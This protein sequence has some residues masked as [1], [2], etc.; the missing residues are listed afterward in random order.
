MDVNVACGNRKTISD[1]TL[2]A[3]RAD[4]RQADRSE[5]HDGHPSGHTLKD[6]AV[7]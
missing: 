5:D 7:T 1:L 3:E 2:A 6:A 4:R